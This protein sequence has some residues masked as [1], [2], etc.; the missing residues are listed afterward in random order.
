MIYHNMV[1]ECRKEKL[2][3]IQLWRERQISEKKHF[4]A[5]RK[6]LAVYVR[7]RSISLSFPTT[8]Y[9]FFSTVTKMNILGLLTRFK[10]SNC[11]ILDE[12]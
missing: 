1:Q 12:T 11:R 8:S 4:E 7:A 10:T 6:F 5:W 9:G 3:S 2:Q